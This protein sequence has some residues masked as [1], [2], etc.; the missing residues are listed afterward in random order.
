MAGGKSGAIPWDVG[1]DEM[2]ANEA[3]L[4]LVNASFRA[5]KY[6]NLLWQRINCQKSEAEPQ[7][8][9]YS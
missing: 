6:R 1:L 3:R 2:L 8:H 4:L 5:L 9:A 7:Y